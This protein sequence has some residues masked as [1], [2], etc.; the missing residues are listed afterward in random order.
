M[1]SVLLAAL[2]LA[3]ASPAGAVT[4]SEFPV[5]GRSFSITSISDLVVA[6]DGN[7]WFTRSDPDV[8]SGAEMQ[9]F[10]PRTERLTNVATPTGASTMVAA[11]GAIWIA[12]PQFG[13]APEILTRIHVATHAAETVP[14]EGR[15]LAIAA[16]PGGP[17]YVAAGG[18]NP[19]GAP[20][21]AP[22]GDRQGPRT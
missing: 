22:P 17:L 7:L 16:A 5:P 12:P 13:G 3:L 18:P 1:R 11:D 6:P 21:P 4:L 19:Q 15:P 14:V 20:T 8:P 2:T 10:D 9:I